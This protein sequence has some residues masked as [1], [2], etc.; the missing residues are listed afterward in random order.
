M[1][2]FEKWYQ[3]YR[4]RNQAEIRP[5]SKWNCRKAW[6]ASMAQE[7]NRIKGILQDRYAELSE[8]L[9][10]DNSDICCEHYES[11]RV[12]IARLL[13]GIEM[14][15]DRYVV[16]NQKR[17][18]I[19][20]DDFRFEESAGEE[21]VKKNGVVVPLGLALMIISETGGLKCEK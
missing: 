18:E 1:D 17:T 3:K 2:E 6:R 14:S 4:M 11:N 12:E 5:T 16:M 7:R 13:E 15:E 9:E 21:A 19:I 20:S 10:V 8:L